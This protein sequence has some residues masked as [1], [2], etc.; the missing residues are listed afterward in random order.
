MPHLNQL[1]AAAKLEKRRLSG[2]LAALRSLWPPDA[3]ISALPLFSEAAGDPSGPPTAP[4]IFH[5]LVPVLIK[6][7][8]T[9]WKEERKGK[10]NV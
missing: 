6:K 1:R 4:S 7:E 5:C 9:E 8:E 10:L 2:N 3:V